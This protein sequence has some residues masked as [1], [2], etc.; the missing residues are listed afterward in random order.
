LTKST[1]GFAKDDPAA[2]DRVIGRII[3]STELLADFPYIGHMDKTPGSHEWVVNGLPYILVY[4]VDREAD[5]L[6][7]IGVFHGARSR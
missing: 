6:T 3:D 5:E 7:V 2:A 4:T 1:H